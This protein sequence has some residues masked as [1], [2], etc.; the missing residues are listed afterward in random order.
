MAVDVL[1]G[2]THTTR[3][4]VS[5]YD[6]RKDDGGGYRAIVDVMSDPDMRAALLEQ[7]KAEADA[8]R[9]KYKMLVELVPIFDAM[10]RTFKK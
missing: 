7:A 6:D 5:L 8:W 1:P 3:C 4:F 9:Q 2:T 10:A